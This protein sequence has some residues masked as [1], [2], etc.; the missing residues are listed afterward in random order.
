MKIKKYGK[1]NFIL[2]SYISEDLCDELIEYFN[3]NKKY[4]VKGMLGK[5]GVSTVDPD[6]KESVDLVVSPGNFDGVIG[7][8]RKHLQKVLETYIKNYPAVECTDKF[9]ITGNYNFQFYPKGGGYKT[10]HCENLN[11]ETMHRHL[12]FM[13][14]LNDVEDGGTEFLHQNIKTKA[15]KGLTIIWPTIWTHTHRGIVSNTKEKYIITGW[16]TYF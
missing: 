12:V 7:K 4:A 2:G 8:Y 10:Y 13:T 11:T 5:G 16:Y 9:N 15:E 6:F 3:Y 14:Y 1:N